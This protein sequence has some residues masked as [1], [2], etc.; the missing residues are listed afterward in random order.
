MR[1]LVE[2]FARESPLAPSALIAEGASAQALLARLLDEPARLHVLQGVVHQEGSACLI[3]IQGEAANL[4]WVE[5]VSYFGVDANAPR[6]RLSTT[7][8]VR[9]EG[10]CD[11]VAVRLLEDSLVREH[12]AQAMPMIVTGDRLVSL[13]LASTLDLDVLRQLE[14]SLSAFSAQESPE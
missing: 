10:A 2:A 3:A 8:G 13:A 4:P 9:L 5:G 12:G 11:E 7:H 14:A 6:L 1:V